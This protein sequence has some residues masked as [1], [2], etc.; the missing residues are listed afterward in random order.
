MS[1]TLHGLFDLP[2]DCGFGLHECD[3]T[4]PTAPSYPSDTMQDMNVTPSAAIN[5]DEVVRQVRDAGRRRAAQPRRSRPPGADRAGDRQRRSR[6][7]HRRR[8][9]RSASAA[10]ASAC[11]RGSRATSWSAPAG[12]CRSRR[13]ATAAGSS[14]S[15]TCGCGIPAC[16]CARTSG[17]RPASRRA[18][19]RSPSIPLVDGT[20]VDVVTGKARSRPALGRPRDQLR[21]PPRRTRRGQ[22]AQRR[23]RQHALSCRGRCRDTRDATQL[24][25]CLRDSDGDG[26]ELVG[27]EPGG[28]VDGDRWRGR[29]RRRGRTGR[30]SP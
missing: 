17:R 13:R 7:D 25:R 6:R 16:C 14:A 5:P 30:R 27:G 23:R 21:D 29:S 12:S 9:S 10:T 18:S 1:S 11:C 4:T 19:G 22:P 28:Q 3:C 24:S 15:T 26:D 20:E 2:Q 8:R